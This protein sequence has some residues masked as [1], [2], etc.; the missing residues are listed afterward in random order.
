MTQDPTH[1][2]Y[3]NAP[4]AQDETYANLRNQLEEYLLF[5]DD[6]EFNRPQADK[7]ITAQHWVRVFHKLNERYA[8]LRLSDL[9]VEMFGQLFYRLSSVRRFGEHAG[10]PQIY[11]VNPALHTLLVL[12]SV[13]DKLE[14][15][16]TDLAAASGQ[17]VAQTLMRSILV[18]DLGEI[19]GELATAHG[20]AT[21]EQA[22]HLDEETIA[23]DAIRHYLQPLLQSGALQPAQQEMLLDKWM[24]YYAIGGGEIPTQPLPPLQLDA[25]NRWWHDEHKQF[26]QHLQRHLPAIADALGALIVQWEREQSQHSALE[27]TQ[28]VEMSTGLQHGRAAYIGQTKPNSMNGQPV[29]MTP[30]E[31]QTHM[32]QH[33]AHTFPHKTESRVRQAAEAPAQA[34]GLFAPIIH[35]LSALA[36]EKIDIA[37]LGRITHLP[38]MRDAQAGKDAK[39]GKPTPTVPEREASIREQLQTL[40]AS[41]RLTEAQFWQADTQL[42][43]AEGHEQKLMHLQHK[44]A[45]V[46]ATPADALSGERDFNHEA[47]KSLRRAKAEGLPIDTQLTTLAE[48]MQRVLQ[49]MPTRA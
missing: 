12:M 33:V 44:L 36:W 35:T 38:L 19:H 28:R 16:G 29:P 42:W 14:K 5:G 2:F 17:W 22:K 20:L 3:D 40:V 27:F 18:H 24:F 48:D 43:D 6:D 49:T 15:S 26:R 37:L 4:I 9:E 10:M 47:A 30:D 1:A 34:Y 25:T 23:K 46:A 39:A 31:E 45:A 32:A 41:G 21:D 13:M 11:E 7:T 8:G